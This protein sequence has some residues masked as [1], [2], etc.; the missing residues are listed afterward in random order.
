MI[1]LRE[2]QVESIL[3]DY[4]R[5]RGFQ[6]PDRKTNT[7]VDIRL[8]GRKGREWFVEVEGNAGPDGKPLKSTSAR[9]THFYR[10][11]GQICRRYG[12]G[13]M[14]ARYGV[15]FPWDE[16][17]REYVKSAEIPLALLKTRIFW[18]MDDGSVRPTR[19]DVLRNQPE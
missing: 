6:V 12:E 19:T 1:L 13:G 8:I 15:G 5:R 2:A 14:K 9:Y 18:V 10:A 7:G 11:L 17:Y 4:F 3:R 16:V